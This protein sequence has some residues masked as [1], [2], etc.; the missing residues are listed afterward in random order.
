MILLINKYGQLTVL[1]M[2]ETKTGH[3]SSEKLK[4]FPLGKQDCESLTR[5][6]RRVCL[7]SERHR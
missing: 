1:N 5:K 7:K 4:K 6:P 2:T 3:V